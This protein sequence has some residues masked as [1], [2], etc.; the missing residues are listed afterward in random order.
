[1]VLLKLKID[2]VE[3][4]FAAVYQH[5][6]AWAERGDL[7]HQ[8]ASYRSSGAC[9]QHPPAMDSLA[10]PFAVEHRLRPAQ[11]LGHVDVAE[12]TLANPAVLDTVELP[13]ACDLQ[14]KHFRLG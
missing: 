4:E 8:L 14:S 13:T 6:L 9:H 7:A 10:H 12:I 1:M 3:I 5:E 11:K 2:R